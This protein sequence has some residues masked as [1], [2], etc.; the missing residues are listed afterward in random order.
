MMLTQMRAEVARVTT[1]DCLPAFG[2][3]GVDLWGNR[4]SPCHDLS[5]T[6]NGQCAAFLPESFSVP[7]GPD[8]IALI[9]G[10]PQ[11]FRREG[12]RG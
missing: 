7:A 9:E 8:G 10:T 3:V 2:V 6:I 11:G 12:A 5:Y 4:T 1:G